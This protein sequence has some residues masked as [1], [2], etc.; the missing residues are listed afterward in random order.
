MKTSSRLVAFAGC[1]AALFAVALGVGRAVGPIDTEPAEAAGHGDAMGGMGSEH[2]AETDHHEVAGLEASSDGYTLTLDGGRLDA[3]SQRLGF[4]ISGP[5]G[6]PVTA[7][8][9]QH[10]R[11]LHLVV[12]RRD[13]TGFQHLHPTLD[14]TS[15]EWSVDADLTPGA[16]RVIAD[17]VP[18]GGAKQVLAADVLVPGEFAPEPLGDDTR[19]AMVDG[20]EVTLART[21]DPN[22]ETLLTATVSR[23]GVPVTDLEP[24]LGAYGHL[25][26]LRDGDIGY[27][28][29]HPEPGE[30]GPEIA[31]RTA[32]PSAGRYRLFLDF[33]HGATVHTAAFTVTIDQPVEEASDD[34]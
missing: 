10:E 31:F 20:Y 29:V 32:F 11:D 23:D 2:L 21:L 30:P 33:R 25:V 1:C 6:V 24:Y 15:G 27:L 16:W 22:D 17:F 18:S 12:V 9:E 13:L 14:T 7:Y 3:G 5:D 34:H 8:D 19:V 4:T 26:A 28:H